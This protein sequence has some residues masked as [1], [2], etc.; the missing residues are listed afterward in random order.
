MKNLVGALLRSAAHRDG[1]S[2]PGKDT[3]GNAASFLKRTIFAPFFQCSPVL[4]LKPLLD[5]LLHSPVNYLVSN[6]TM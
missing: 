1:L 6:R 3:Y 4:R 2:N 5:L